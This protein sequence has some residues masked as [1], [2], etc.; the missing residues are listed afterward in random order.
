MLSHGNLRA[1]AYALI[2]AWHYA[3]DDVLVHA[4]PIFHAHGLYVGVNV[5]LMAGAAMIFLPRFDPAEVLACFGRATVMMGVPTFYTRLLDQPGLSHESTAGMRLFI[6]G[7]APLLS[8]THEAFRR[9]TG[10]TILE[11]YGMTETSMLTSNPYDGARIP[12]S[13]GLPLKDVQVRITH[14][15][16]GHVLGAGEI[17]AIEV[18]GPN[19]FS[20]YWGMP[21]KTASEFRADG[22]FITGDIGKID[23]SGYLWILDRTKDIVITGGYNVY[24]K[25]VEQELDALP[26]V[27][28]AA[29]IGVPHPDFG[30]A[31]VAVVV[32][33]AG[34]AL[35]E[36]A[37]ID[38]LRGRLAGYKLPKRVLFAEELPRN[39]MGKIQKNVLRDQHAGLFRV[40]AK[41]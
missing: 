17:G 37:L 41:A 13:V 21:E 26:D 6:S 2:A 15:E 16:T 11:R 34:A 35:R 39:T 24:P 10:H 3:A 36:R 1:N 20:G 8:D 38:G 19:V 28:E 30:E 14:P 4:L 5:S 27:E 31:V 12:G 40:L 23:E 22:F 25:E 18:K 32:P 9:R 33:R 7:S 29:V